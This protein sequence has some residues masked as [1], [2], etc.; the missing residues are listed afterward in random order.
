MVTAS[1]AEAVVRVAPTLPTGRCLVSLVLDILSLMSPLKIA[2]ATRCLNVPL[3]ESLRSAARFG[4]TGVQLDAREEIRPGMLTDTGRRQL[5]HTLGELGLS[6][7]SLAFPTR[8]S[9]YD[10][11]QLDARVAAAKQVME[12]AWN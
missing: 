5:Q 9:F 8:R 10:E 1:T 11:E 6:I 2:V 7:A 4:A 3:K 12:L